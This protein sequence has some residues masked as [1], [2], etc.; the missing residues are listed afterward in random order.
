ME[1]QV[2]V[3]THVAIIMDGNGRWASERGLPRAAGHRA[4][5]ETVRAI[6]EACVECGVRILTLYTFS[7]ENWQRPYEEIDALF[8]IL[9]DVI[10]READ[11]LRRNGVQ[12]RHIGTLEGVPSVLA[13]RIKRAVEGTRHNERL[14]LNVA[15]NYGARSEILRAVRRIVARGVPPELV[16][17]QSIGDNLDTAGLPDPDLVIRTAGEM[18]LSNFLL[19]QAA[20]AEFWATNVYWP[21]FDVAEFTRALRAF[22]LRRRRFGGL[23]PSSPSERRGVGGNG[24]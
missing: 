12:I 19:W 1:Q 6:I 3:P 17:E 15:F 10:D 21:D 5:T 18:R 23:P 8:A 7:T 4:G 14:I 11:D 22:G 20:Y 9:S 16:D 24:A 2:D 13:Q